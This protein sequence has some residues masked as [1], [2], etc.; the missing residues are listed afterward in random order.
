ML[1]AVATM[2]E[3]LEKTGKNSAIFTHL[4]GEGPA[5]RQVSQLMSILDRTGLLFGFS[6]NPDSAS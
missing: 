1:F 4:G 6:E 2:K 5:V 3:I